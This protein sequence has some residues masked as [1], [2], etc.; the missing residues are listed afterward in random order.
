MSVVR[1]DRLEILEYLKRSVRRMRELAAQNPGKFAEEM[2]AVADDIAD[3]VARLEGELIE[4]GHL[5]TPA[6]QP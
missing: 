3:D 2:L 5:P 4:A 1:N 6:N